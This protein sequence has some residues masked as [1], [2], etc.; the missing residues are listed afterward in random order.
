MYYL[1][2]VDLSITFYNFFSEGI[3]W[4][5]EKVEEFIDNA[6]SFTL[7]DCTIQLTITFQENVNELFTIDESTTGSRRTK[8]H[9]LSFVIISESSQAWQ[10]IKISESST[11]LFNFFSGHYSK[12]NRIPFKV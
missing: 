2:N 3:R 10:M 12:V 4:N 9:F 8:H 6:H 5:E 11:P 7:A 1:G